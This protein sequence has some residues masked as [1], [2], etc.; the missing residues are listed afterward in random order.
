MNSSVF[1]RDARGRSPL[2]QEQVERTRQRILDGLVR[3]LARGV[4]RL[5]MPAVAREAGVSVPTVY[6]Y[7]KSKEELLR[8][9]EDMHEAH[10]GGVS[11]WSPPPTDFESL[12]SY[13]RVLFL[14]YEEMEPMLRTLM[15]TAAGS[16]A[17][18]TQ[19]RAGLRTI[20]DWLD[21]VAP[22]LSDEDHVR[23]RDL[24]AVLTGSPTQRA[25]KDYLNLTAGDAAERVS[26]AVRQL[27]RAAQATRGQK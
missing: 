8:G 13:L 23:L 18:Q 4:A 7:F 11:V 1:N 24:I 19:M 5:S 14:R 10:L 21:S 3:V 27:V 12:S 20:E 17:P 25:F 16:P 2:Q 26:W 6:R 15:S 9:L 22:S